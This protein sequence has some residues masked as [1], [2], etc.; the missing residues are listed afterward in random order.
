MGFGVI[1]A[2]GVIVVSG[3]T[4]GSGIT[5]GSGALLVPGLA[6]ALAYTNLSPLPGLMSDHPL[7]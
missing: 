1:L 7:S 3:V 2:F 5:G 4:V 6:L